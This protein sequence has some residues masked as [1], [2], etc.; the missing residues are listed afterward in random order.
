[1]NLLDSLKKSTYQ[2]FSQRRAEQVNE[3]IV[4]TVGKEVLMGHSDN[5]DG[6]A[7]TICFDWKMKKW[8]EKVGFYRKC[9]EDEVTFRSEIKT[10]Q[11]TTRVEHHKCF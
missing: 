6:C 11:R 2:I 5:D 7:L 1:M 3:T 10:N 8:E 9:M 4:S